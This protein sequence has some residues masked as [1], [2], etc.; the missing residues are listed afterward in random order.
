MITVFIL[1]GPDK[2]QVLEFEK[3]AITLGR[4]DENEIKLI[5]RNVSRKHL[6]IIKE[7]EN[8]FIE[9]LESKNG[10]FIDGRQIVP[11]ARIQISEITPIL[12]GMSV[13]C[14][15]KA[16]MEHVKP[17]LDMVDISES[18]E[19]V[20]RHSIV[21]YQQNMDLLEKFSDI[22]SSASALNEMTERVLEV[23]FQILKKIS[24]ATLILLDPE[25][26]D[27]ADSVSKVSQPSDDTSTSYNL[28]V[29]GHVLK[30]NKPF[31]FLDALDEYEDGLSETLRVS[32][33]RSVLCLPLSQ[34]S[35]M[36]GLMY[37]DSMEQ[38]PSFRKEDLYV[39]KLLSEKIGRRLADFLL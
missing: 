10:T 18:D 15:G 24:R 27:I 16:C 4:S 12:I 20:L 29:V 37:I 23:I 22:L 5:D 9:D 14:L 35:K 2:D 32:K 3:E 30:T 8:Y 19:Q 7:Q 33:I 36:L 28:E 6:K 13:L 17:Y 25:T 26:G 1:T 31:Q 11:N 21:N 34:R 39:M 38:S